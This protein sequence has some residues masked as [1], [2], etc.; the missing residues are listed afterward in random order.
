[1]CGVFVGVL[2]LCEYSDKYATTRID[3]W[4]LCGVP[5]ISKTLQRRLQNTEDD[6]F[7]TDQENQIN[8]TS[9]TSLTHVHNRVY[10]SGLL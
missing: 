1:M 9:W 10:K 5:L 4:G 7:L 2:I 3:V 6:N 8:R